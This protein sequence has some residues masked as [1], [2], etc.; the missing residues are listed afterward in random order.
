MESFHILTG[1]ISSGN[2]GLIGDDDDF[3]SLFP[4]QPDGICRFRKKF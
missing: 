4:Q 1:I 3:K 2:A